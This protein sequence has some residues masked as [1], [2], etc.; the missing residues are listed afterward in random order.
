VPLPGDPVARRQPE[1]NPPT[2]DPEGWIRA[3]V[4][5]AG[6]SV[7]P[8]ARPA[9]EDPESEGLEESISVVGT[10][11]CLESACSEVGDSPVP[12]TERPL[13]PAEELQAFLLDHNGHRDRVQL[14]LSRWADEA[15]LVRS[16]RALSQ[17]VP[18]SDEELV[19]PRRSPH[20]ARGGADRCV[21]HHCSPL[22][23]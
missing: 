3:E 21:W 13:I 23:A 8:D 4:E 12:P 6:D 16:A 20:R 19:Q 7:S 10:G 15:L 14:A 22:K 9:A 18:V 5:L 11:T 17:A 2:S 1:G